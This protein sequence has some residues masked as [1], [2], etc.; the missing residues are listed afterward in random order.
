MT[1]SAHQTVAKIQGI[2]LLVKGADRF[3]WPLE[4]LQIGGFTEPLQEQQEQP[5]KL[6]KKT[7]AAPVIKN[8][9]YPDLLGQ[10]VNKS[11]PSHIGPKGERGKEGERER[12]RER[13]RERE[14]VGERER[15]RETE[16]ERARERE[17]ERERE[18]ERERVE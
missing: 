1:R 11:E 8:V 16:R 15:E 6:V 3:H 5:Q 13:E 9:E 14:R 10:K 7:K 18:S 4:K 2:V 12:K 17:R